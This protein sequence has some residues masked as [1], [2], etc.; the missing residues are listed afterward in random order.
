[1][2]QN[3]QSPGPIKEWIQAKSETD[4]LIGEINEKL[5]AELAEMDIQSV[6][7]EIAFDYKNKGFN[8]AWSH[9]NVAYAA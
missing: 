8:V 5:K 1:V 9:K 4:C 2:K 6:V 7:P 3:W